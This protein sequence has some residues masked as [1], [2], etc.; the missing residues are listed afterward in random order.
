MTHAE[1]RDRNRAIWFAHKNGATI[2][3]LA[4][5]HDLS[6]PYV[7]RLVRTRHPP[8]GV[9]VPVEHAEL[10][11]PMHQPVADAS[12]EEMR[13]TRLAHPPARVLALASR[14]REGQTLRQIGDAYGISH[15]WVR[16]LLAA[17][18][19]TRND[20]GQAQQKLQRALKSRAKR[21]AKC[22]RRWGLTL[23]DYAAF[24]KAYGNTAKRGSPMHR[25]MEQ[26]RNACR[27]GIE[28]RFTFPQ[29]WDVWERS[30]K[31]SR[32]GRG[33]GYCMGRYGDVGPYAAD[34]VYICTIG[35]NFSDSHNVDHPRRK[36][37][38]RLP[39]RANYYKTKAGKRWMV[40]VPQ[41]PG[42]RHFGGFDSRDAAESYGMSL[43]A[44]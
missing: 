41:L 13:A 21:E 1:S 14:Y 37:S 25:Y 31:W 5:N 15:E 39:V 24:V 4:E 11:Q 18:G 17:I 44:Q 2:A 23:P 29:W 42:K 26:K 38:R 40:T 16:Q 43:L 32:R 28:W 12:P 35:Q 7:H 30:G 9:F 10:I 22:L 3:A 19:I 6:Y 36:K 34:N 20:G 8:P 33:E 27:R